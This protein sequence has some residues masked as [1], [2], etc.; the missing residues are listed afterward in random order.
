MRKW[1]EMADACFVDYSA[2]GAGLIENYDNQLT[3]APEEEGEFDVLNDETFGDFGDGDVEFDWEE[4]HEKFA[5]VFDTNGDRTNDSGF[6][7]AEKSYR[8]QEEFVE[9]NIRQL[10]IDDED[11]QDDPAIVNV[12]KARPIPRKQQS[13]DALFGPSSP[14]SLL[15]TEY[16]VSPTSKNIWGSPIV[17]S[18]RISKQGCDIQTL[19]DFAKTASRDSPVPT[20]HGPHS[21]APPM[22]LPR[23]QTLE[24][25]EGSLIPRHR[26]SSKPKV[27]T[28][29][30][31]ERQLRGEATQP[32]N[33]TPPPMAQFVQ[34]GHPS[35]GN[36]GVLPPNMGN[37]PPRPMPPRVPAGVSPG[38]MAPVINGRISPLQGSVGT[39]LAPGTTPPYRNMGTPLT[40][41]S[42]VLGMVSD[43]LDR[44]SPTPPP[45][46][47]PFTFI[48]ARFVSPYA[49][50]NQPQYIGKLL[51]VFE[52]NI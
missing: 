28:A 51:T 12:R 45:L 21:R 18:P 3:E 10:V 31:L 22:V 43:I 38:M 14:P 34:N 13:L 49:Q 5:E 23:A 15:D 44:R 7:T 27:L 32:V 39:P 6:N 46:S 11:I 9:R 24:E 30:E 36:F 19:F 33:R 35:P 8:S 47:S 17:D 48:P 50:G 26:K 37:T 16:L 52:M 1:L 2:L 4:Q 40:R 25:I 29:E 42:P 41:Q 20:I